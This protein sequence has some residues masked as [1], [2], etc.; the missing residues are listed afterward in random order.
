MPALWAIFRDIVLPIFVL[1]GAGVALERR[2]KLDVGTMSKLNFYVFVPALLFKSLIESTIEFADL[3]VVALFQAVL[4]F[5]LLGINSGVMK[6]ARVGPQ[7]AS[8]F[9]LATIFCNSGNFGIP[10]VTFAFPES[11]DKAVSY[12]AITIMVQNLLTFTLGL[13]IV[14]HGEAGLGRSLKQTLKLPFVYVIAAALLFK[15]FAVPVTEWP[16]VWNPID[17]AGRGLVAVALLTLGVQMAKTPR[18]PRPGVLG[19]ANVMRLAAAPVVAFGL[20]KLF[21]L[22]GMLARLLVIASAG[23][24]AVNTVLIGLEFDNQPEFA[25]SAVFYSTLFSAVTVAVT[26]FLVRAFM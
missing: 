2:F 12:Q 23:P 11:P 25:A 24:S 14:G 17:Y 4:I 21:G 10:L 18:V 15:Y 7:L 26:I 9:L 6:L 5:T 8:V 19:L 3:G 22:T 16:Y 1:V 13:V 20:V